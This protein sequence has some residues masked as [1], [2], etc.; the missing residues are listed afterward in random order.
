MPSFDNSASGARVTP[1]WKVPSARGASASQAQVASRLRPRIASIAVTTSSIVTTAGGDTMRALFIA[2]TLSLLCAAPSLA[3]D[4]RG[5][6]TGAGG[7]AA[8][9]DATSG[10]V[11]L[12]AGVR[13]APH[14]LVF[15]NLGQFHNLQPSDAL[16]AVDST[17][18]TLAGSLGL[19]VVGTA[20]VPALYTVGGVRDEI[21][22]RAR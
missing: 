17:M 8:S 9:T 5:Y 2:A 1:W 15:G 20:R 22:T 16:P 6:V 10:N 19:N 12:D 14:R 4:E 13:V 21:P 18:A 7:F 11:L 3:Q